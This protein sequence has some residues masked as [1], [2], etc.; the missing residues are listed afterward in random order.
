MI[1]NR[2]KETDQKENIRKKKNSIAC[3]YN[4]IHISTFGYVS[5]IYA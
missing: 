3:M 1:T 5:K 2:E 4:I